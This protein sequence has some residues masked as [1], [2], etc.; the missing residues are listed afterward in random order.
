MEPFARGITFA[1]LGVA[2]AGC[3]MVNED[4]NQAITF[5]IDPPIAACAVIRSTIDPNKPVEELGTISGGGGT[6]RVGRTSRDLVV[7]CQAPG[8]RTVTSVVKPTA[9]QIARGSWRQTLSGMIDDWSG[10]SF[11]YPAD[12]EITMSPG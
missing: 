10:A 8:Y 9:T 6:I 4:L 5:R 7:R 12:V 3:A 1:A 2:L 11:S